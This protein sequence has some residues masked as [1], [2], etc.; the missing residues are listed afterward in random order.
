VKLICV[1]C[2]KAVEIGEPM[3]A[4][5]SGEL[6]HQSC[7]ESR[8]E[9]HVQ[10]PS[11]TISTPTVEAP[12]VDFSTRPSGGSSTAPEPCLLPPAPKVCV[13][14]GDPCIGACPVCR[15]LVC[16]DF[17]FNGFN[18]AGRHES[19]CPGAACQREKDLTV[20]P[21]AIKIVTGPIYDTIDIKTGRNGH[22]ARKARR[23][24]RSGRR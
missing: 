17:G 4:N 10:L 18:C 3:L 8:S 7:V 19:A 5:Q 12:K 24:R 23:E 11:V 22:A 21:M 6:A 16:Y 14:C 20:K 9:I 15:K 1:L 2:E 13:V